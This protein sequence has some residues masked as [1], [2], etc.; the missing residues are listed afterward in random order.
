[1][2]R[3]AA[4]AAA[5][6]PRLSA[7]SASDSPLTIAIP[8][9]DAC[10]ATPFVFVVCPGACP[11]RCAT[12]PAPCAARG[13]GVGSAAS[14]AP[15]WGAG[16]ACACAAATWGAGSGIFEPTPLESGC[17]PR[18]AAVGGN[19]GD[20]RGRLPAV[21][22]FVPHV[23]VRALRQREQAVDEELARKRP[24]LRPLEREEPL[25]A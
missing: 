9:D 1:M 23:D 14:S 11:G 17:V 5:R 3:G 8:G 19:V 21:H 25:D 20:G 2:M 18:R 10:A 16:T 4:G 15:A 24:L 22:A 7:L 12:W 6:A 13:G